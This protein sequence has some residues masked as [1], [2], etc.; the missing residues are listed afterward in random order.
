MSAPT[1]APPTL[2]QVH[3]R[4][5]R[6][7]QAFDG[8][9][10]ALE[11][12]QYPPR[13]V[14]SY[15]AADDAPASEVTGQPVL[16]S[17]GQRPAPRLP[18]GYRP[19]SVWKSA[20][21][22]YR[23]LILSGGAGGFRERL[24]RASQGIYKTIQGMNEGVGADG[25]FAVLPEFSPQIMDRVTHHTLFADADHYPVAGNHMTFLRNP[26][27]SRADGQRH[28][29]L[30]AYWS[31]EG[32]AATKSSP[33]LAEFT[34]KLNKLMVVVYLTQE[35]IDDSGVALEQYVSRKVA[36]EVNFKVGDAL[37]N[38][39]GAGQPKGILNSAARVT[40]SKESGQ[41]AASLVADNLWKM[42]GRLY[43][44]ALS[45]AKWY[46]NQDV[47]P[48]LLAL[49][50]GSGGNPV[51]MPPGGASAAPY[52]TILGMPIQVTEFNPTLGTEGDIVLANL[53]QGYVTITKGAVVQ[54]QSAHVEFLSDQLALRFTLRIDGQPWETAPLTPYKGSNTLSHFVTLETRA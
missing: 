53:R 31:G 8:I 45:G 12:P 20:G 7:S 29:G 34:L 26:E 17:A 41:A 44:P 25:G 11:E 50:V 13:D 1:S 43:P 21:D 49:N 39:S 52:G 27:T 48:K 28:G 38:G 51:F 40:V 47:Y 16:K 14:H 33:K 36:E 9:Q 46:I 10:Q 35:L 6:L 18:A 15:W 23:D 24:T 19:F 32:A 5:D 2:D 22:F 3:E 42:W 54:A 30:Q 37:M 4:L